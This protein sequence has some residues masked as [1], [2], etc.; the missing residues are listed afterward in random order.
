MRLIQN[1]AIAGVIAIM[2]ALVSVVGS[3]IID[4]SF[5][6]AQAQV[7]SGIDVVGNQRISRDTILTYV[8]I[9]PGQ[10][11]SAVKKDETIQALFAT[12]LFKDVSIGSSGSRLIVTVIENPIVNGVSFVG[13]D[14]IKD[15]DLRAAALTKARATFSQD[16]VDADVEGLKQAYCFKPSTSAST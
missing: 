9:E 12:G 1:Q 13:N 3:P 7:I 14:K 15:D 16:Q 5:S 11:A 4:A 6:Q 8:T 10:N 2:A